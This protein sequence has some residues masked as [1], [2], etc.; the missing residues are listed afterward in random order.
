MGNA[1]LGIIV[2]SELPVFME[3]ASLNWNGCNAALLIPV[4]LQYP[5]PF[6][7]PLTAVKSAARKPKGAGIMKRVEIP[8]W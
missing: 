7:G 6:L 5:S 1:A 2:G 4:F 8:Y 3:I